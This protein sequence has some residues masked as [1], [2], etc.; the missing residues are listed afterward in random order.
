MSETLE[1]KVIGLESPTKEEALS[2]VDEEMAEFHKFFTNKLGQSPADRR[3][4][5]YLK[6]YLVWKVLG[7]D[8]M[9]R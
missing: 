3:E 6:T 2:S 5:S 8:R 7:P 4:I 1:T 9:T